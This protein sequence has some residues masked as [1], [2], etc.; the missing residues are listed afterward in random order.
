MSPRPVSPVTAVHLSKLP[1]SGRDL[2]LLLLLL[3]LSASQASFS[4]LWKLETALLFCCWSAFAAHR[5]EEQIPMK[6]N[7]LPLLLRRQQLKI[8]R[9]IF[10][11]HLWDY[12]SPGPIWS[13]LSWAE[14]GWVSMQDLVSGQCHKYTVADELHF[15]VFCAVPFTQPCSDHMGLCPGSRR[16]GHCNSLTLRVSPSWRL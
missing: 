12:H 10:R 5:A 15:T 1:R 7:E 3:H 14:L 9:A 16:T 4:F 6:Y 13:E 2:L 11:R 8:G